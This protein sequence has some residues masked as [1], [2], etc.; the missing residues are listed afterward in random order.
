MKFRTAILAIALGVAGTGLVTGPAQAASAGPSASTERGWNGGFVYQGNDFAFFDFKDAKVS[1]CDKEKDGHAVY[2]YL[3]IHGGDTDIIYDNTSGCTSD[4]IN[5][6]EDYRYVTVCESV[7][8]PD[9][10]HS[11]VYL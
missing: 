5:E 8:G 9:W 3:R 7:W 2:A 11:P 1:V 4:S 6:K 10:C